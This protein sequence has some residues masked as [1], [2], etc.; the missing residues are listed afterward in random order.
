MQGAI[1]AAAAK[2]ENLGPEKITSVFPKALMEQE[3]ADESG[4][5][6]PKSF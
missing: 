3:S 4:V 1:A 6:T 5:G 2:R